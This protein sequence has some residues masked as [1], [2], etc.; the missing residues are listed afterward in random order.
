MGPTPAVKVLYNQE[1]Y[2]TQAFPNGYNPTSPFTFTLTGI[3]NPIT[4]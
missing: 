2:I 1:V 3:T 4:A